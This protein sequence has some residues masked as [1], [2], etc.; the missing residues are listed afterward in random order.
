MKILLSILLVTLFSQITFAG[1]DESS[2]TVCENENYKLKIKREG[3]FFGEN[4]IILKKAG[5]FGQTLIDEEYEQDWSPTQEFPV[6]VLAKKEKPKSM[7]D[8]YMLNVSKHTA[9]VITYP[10]YGN[11]NDPTNESPTVYLQVKSVKGF[12]KFDIKT[13]CEQSNG[14]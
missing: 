2:T 14:L 4:R 13:Q 10:G 6:E 11:L 3:S 1:Y 12:L 5:W 9:T 8:F 7:S